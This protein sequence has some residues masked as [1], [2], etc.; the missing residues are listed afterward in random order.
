MSTK[1]RITLDPGQRAAVDAPVAAAT[2]V[3]AGAGTGKTS[4]LVERYLALLDAGLP[5]ERLLALTFTLKAAGEMRERVRKEVN[6]RQAPLSRRLSGAWIM[7]FHQFGYRFIKDNAPALGIDPGVDVVSIAEF[8]RIKR[9]LRTRFENGR[10]PDVPSDFGGEPPPPT[11]LGSLFDT[12]MKV[13]WHCRGIMLS[14]DELRAL[15]KPDDRPAYIARVDTVVALAREYENEL[16]R[17][18]LLDFS[19]MITIPARA[20]QN[21]PALARAYQGAFDHILVD[22]FQDTS[23]AQNELLRVLSG[24]N[25]SRVTV[26]GDLKQ[27]IYRWRDARVENVTE[28]PDPAPHE[29]TMNYRSRQAILDLAHGLVLREDDLRT[30]AVPL[31]AHRTGGESSVLLFHPSEGAGRHDDE[32]EALG[33]WVDHWLGRAAA[34]AHWELESPQTPLE[35]HD[36]AVLVRKFS[37]NKLMPEIER[38]FQRRGVPFAVVGGANRAEARALETWHAWVSLLLPGDRPVDLVAVLEAPPYSVTEASLA[39]LFA[40][41]QDRTVAKLLDDDAIA[42]VQDER[43]ATAVRDLRA[44]IDQAVAVWR[45]RGFREFLVWSIESSP[46]RTRLLRDGAQPAA[47]DELLREMLD[48]ADALARR[49]E[50]NLGTFLDHLRASLEERKFREEGDVILPQGRVAVMTVHQAKG[51]EFPAVA[52][53]DVVESEA[54]PESFLVS[55]ASGLYFGERTGR[56]WKRQKELAENYAREQHMEDVEERCVLYVALT[57]ARDHLWVSASSV[58]GRKLLKDSARPWLFT[59]LVECARELKVGR[60]IREVGDAPNVVAASTALARGDHGAEVAVRAWTELRDRNTTQAADALLPD[61]LVTVTWADL[62]LFARDPEQFKAWLASGRVLADP[63]DSSRDPIVVADVPNA[64]SVPRGVD[65]A[66][67][68]TFVHEVLQ[69]L[70]VD[71][72]PDAAID[73]ALPRYDFAQQRSAAIAAARTLVGHALAAR[74]AGPAPGARVEVPFIVRLD[75]LLVRGIIDRIDTTADSTMIT[76]YK[77]GERI[78]EHIFQVQAYLW[79]VSRAGVAET[80]RGRVVYLRDSGVEA[81]DVSADGGLEKIAREMQAFLPI[82]RFDLAALERAYDGK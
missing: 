17:R 20:L 43:D 27:S 32:A 39:E 48:V 71:G 65:P 81:V 29:L 23:A 77:V 68:G 5:M 36:V 52:V 61:G 21:D 79:A 58:E 13:V 15:V 72:N 16:A 41:S 78:D 38:V 53:V 59:D 66:E 30:A 26:V 44:S 60:E 31:S 62:A 10:V 50:L 73:A 80:I 64:S 56:P 3:V 7:N 67:F 24:G 49:G 6:A 25:F 34:P 42:R 70:A 63:E 8:E 11:K 40:H 4:V 12:L 57:R 35:P 55:R 54:P 9:F 69:R 19:D 37:S 75:Q 33:A 76:D 82:K 45:S 2:N 46:L 74:I 47:V 18:G 28:F 14:P 22:E 51:L 1:P